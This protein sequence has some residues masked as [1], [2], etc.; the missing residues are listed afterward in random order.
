M[1]NA[2]A[3]EHRYT[4][5]DG[6]GFRSL[7][8]HAT[9]GTVEALQVTS[10]LT[11]D[12]AVEQAICSRASRYSLIQPSLVA[13]VRAIDR[14][15]TQLR[16]TA[17]A[18]QGVRLSRLLADLEFGNETLAEGTLLELAAAVINAV[19]T[20]HALPGI[21]SHGALNPTHIV[22]RHDGSVLLTDGVFGSAFELLYWNRQQLW[23]QF[24]LALPM[25]A[26]THRFDQRTDVTQLA[27]VVLAIALRR[28]LQADDYPRG[29]PDLVLQSTPSGGASHAS[30]L[31]MWLHQSLQLHPRSVLASAVDAK[32]LFAQVLAAAGTNRRMAQQSLKE[33]AGRLYGKSGISDQRAS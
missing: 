11:A 15:G 24:G 23:R 26:S 13:S 25:S 20:L 19:A 1:A 29:V 21:V 14:R 31:R 2:V 7:E 5:D 17:D 32:Q 9:Y 33:L 3:A 18:P 12:P 30:A 8:R 22:L 16:V 27:A 28:Q 10:A 6:L 4:L